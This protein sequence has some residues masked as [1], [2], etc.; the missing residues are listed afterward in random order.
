MDMPSSQIM[1][2]V[3]PLGAGSGLGTVV[4]NLP[5]ALVSS[6]VRTCQWGAT[7]LSPGIFEKGKRGREWVI[8][9]QNKHLLPRGADQNS[10]SHSFLASYG[11]RI[12]R[13]TVAV[14]IASQ[15]VRVRFEVH[16]EAALNCMVLN[17]VFNGF[18][19]K[20]IFSLGVGQC[21]E[22]EER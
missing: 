10:I 18:R 5:S 22:K 17:A 21:S 15:I 14:E 4:V 6:F 13:L 11:H 12:I 8:S 19:M 9:A 2:I 3:S 16:Y 7:K 20:S 1:A